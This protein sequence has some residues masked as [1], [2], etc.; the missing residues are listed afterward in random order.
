MALNFLIRY[1]TWALIVLLVALGVNL[2][3]FLISYRHAR[4]DALFIWRKEAAVRCRWL[5]ALFVVLCAAIGAVLWVRWKEPALPPAA[6]VTPPP[7]TP[8]QTVET[9]MPATAPTDTPLSAEETVAPTPVATL[10]PPATQPTA[11]PPARPYI[12]DVIL[13]RGVSDA[14]EPVEPGTQ[15]PAGPERLYAF[16]SYGNMTGPLTWSQAW[17]KDDTELARETGPW[18]YGWAGRA[19]VFYMPAG[20]WTPGAYSV[21]FYIGDLLE[22]ESTFIIQ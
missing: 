7:A 3:A 5:L 16:F 21:R 6:R 19:Y 17:Y 22:A 18:T 4:H 2:A 1:S 15:F 10:T 9:A 20:G 12:R 8:T 11:T 13:A 14:R